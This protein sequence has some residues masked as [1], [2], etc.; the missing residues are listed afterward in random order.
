[1][2]FF[3]FVSVTII[4]LSVWLVAST[5]VYLALLCVMNNC[6]PKQTPVGVETNPGPSTRRELAFMLFQACA[7]LILSGFIYQKNS[8]LAVVIWFCGIFFYARFLIAYR[9]TFFPQSRIV[10]QPRLVGV[11]TNPGP[12]VNQILADFSSLDIIQAYADIPARTGEL[13]R[14]MRVTKRLSL[15]NLK[16]NEKIQKKNLQSTISIS[17]LNSILETLETQKNMVVHDPKPKS[18]R[19]MLWK[20]LG[21]NRHSNL[22]RKNFHQNAI[23]THLAKMHGF[24]IRSLIV[25]HRE[26]FVHNCFD[27]MESDESY[28]FQ[29]S[30]STQTLCADFVP[31]PLLVGI[32]TNPGPPTNSMPLLDLKDSSRA[33]H[34]RRF[35]R[36]PSQNSDVGYD[37]ID[38]QK[39]IRAMRDIKHSQMNL[40]GTT[41]THEISPD[42]EDKITEIVDS[43]NML[44]SKLDMKDQ[45]A[46]MGVVFDPLQNA[47]MMNFFKLLPIYACV[48]AFVCSDKGPVVLK[49][50]VCT[51]ALVVLST[52]TPA[53][54]WSL[55]KDS[56]TNL[57]SRMSR[58]TDGRIEAQ[59]SNDSIKDI[60]SV[61]YTLTTF[62]TVKSAPPGKGLDKFLSSLGDLPKRQDGIEHALLWVVTIIERI[63]NYIR[64]EVLN[65]CPVHI[66]EQ[67]NTD[68]KDWIAKI[69]ILSQEM[70]TNSLVINTANADRVFELIS[71]GNSLLSR[72]GLQKEASGLRSVIGTYMNA[73]KKLQ[74][75]F[76]QANIRGNDLRMSPVCVLLRGASG[77]GKSTITVPLILEI[78]GKLLPVAQLEDFQLNHMDFIYNRQPEHIYWDG[79]RGQMCTI[80][81]DFGQARDVVGTPDNEFMNLIR[82]GNAFPNT[83]HMADL[84]SK[85]VNN[86]RSK[87]VFASTNMRNFNPASII[88]PEAVMRRFDIIVDVI[89]KL[90][91]SLPGYTEDPWSRRLD[92]TKLTSA[93]EPEVYEYMLFSFRE[94]RYV[95]ITTYSA[96]IDT[97]AKMYQQRTAEFEEY[98][99]RIA[100]MKMEISNDRLFSQADCDRN[101]IVYANSLLTLSDLPIPMQSFD[102]DST[103]REAM[104]REC[105]NIITHGVT[106][107]SVSELQLMFPSLFSKDQSFK[108]F[109]NILR[110]LADLP[111]FEERMT[112][113]RMCDASVS[114]FFCKVV[115]STRSRFESYFVEFTTYVAKFLSDHPI[116]RNL[117]MIFIF[118]SCLTISLKLITS[119][120][121]TSEK[122]VVPTAE[123]DSPGH[124]RK[125]KQNRAKLLRRFGAPSAPNAAQLSSEGGADRVCDQLIDKIVSRNVYEVHTPSSRGRIG[126]ATFVRGRLFLIPKH[127]VLSMKISNELGYYFE[128]IITLKSVNSNIEH[129]IPLSVFLQGKTCTSSD[130]QDIV[131][132]EAP[133]NVNP[134]YDIVDN[135]IPTSYASTARDYFTKLVVPREGGLVEYCSHALPVEGIEVHS[136]DGPFLIRKGYQCDAPTSAGDCG[137]FLFVLDPTSKSAKIIGSH[138]AG[139]N[140]RKAFS[141]AIFREDLLYAINLF[142]E[143]VI[144][145]MEEDRYDQLESAPIPGAFVPLFTHELN[146]RQPVRNKVTP[147]RLCDLWGDTKYAPSAL[148]SKTLTDGTVLI[149]MQ[150]ALKTYAGQSMFLDQEVIDQCTDH[151]LSYFINNSDYSKV[152]APC[153]FTFDDAVCGVEGVDFCESLS[154][155][156]SAGF[157]WCVT[158]GRNHPGKTYFFGRDGPFDMTGPGAIEIRQQ[159]E[160]ILVDAR[161]GRRQLHVYTDNLKDEK[162]KIEKVDAC[163]TRLFSGCPLGL[164]IATRMY[165]LDFSMAV[166]RNKISNGIAVGINPYSNDWQVL[167]NQLQSKGKRVIAGDFSGYDGSLQPQVLNSILDFINNW[168]DDGAENKRIRTVLWCEV[169]ASRHING[170][171]IYEW[172]HSLP[173]GH[174]LTVIINSIY[175]HIAF[176]YAWVVAH[177]Y[178]TTSLYT[179]NDNVYCVA[180]GD[181][182]VLNVSDSALEFFNQETMPWLLA[183]IGLK[184][185]N[186]TKD[187]SV[188]ISRELSEVSFLKRK[189]RFDE[190]HDRC[191]APLALESILEMPY[192]TKEGPLSNLITEGNV[193]RCVEELALHSEAVFNEWFPKIYRAS[194]QVLGHVPQMSNYRLLQMKCLSSTVEY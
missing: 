191:L 7:I 77:V 39:I 27:I 174:V 185:T 124:G 127:F 110:R 47:T 73:L 19:M 67:T 152:H 76:D 153:I 108:V 112:Q 118:L 170:N 42:F 1:M 24:G 136:V 121:G 50:T 23:S 41:L 142:S 156:T 194:K 171:D 178:D 9:E 173:S 16:I 12:N 57:F 15:P 146:V 4:C 181:D 123:D 35:P 180:Y 144:C 138:S 140:E 179:Y 115:S 164:Q 8:F 78:L 145:Q 157:P 60:V 40:F 192:W 14:T 175:D 155:T 188:S 62:I 38:K 103:Q 117:G 59:V 56:A 187:D 75:P 183:G 107:A 193:D 122:N 6:F 34:L 22:Y 102:L 26:Y 2:M 49:G 177:Q 98:R 30:V 53:D 168:Y 52:V 161:Q 91:F 64:T 109:M 137:S 150:I 189:W 120:N 87:M 3:S 169:F 61:L 94:N 32:E 21:A 95:S 48:I 54:L 134:H 13:K 97:I 165:F 90:A 133:K 45:M 143:Q 63:V 96:M 72:Y 126:F 129:K 116:I 113:G 111:D 29:K 86:F 33:N 82:C 104:Q 20:Y 17:L 190:A 51:V 71:L 65:Q 186:E 58:Q 132:C 130:G 79:Y 28:S 43:V 88:E 68:V 31:Q 147:S 176:R 10:P 131:M 162:R 69:E 141:S 37:K 36:Q 18:L 154:R 125:G 70:H 148:R 100:H 101:S 55:I 46:G 167:A 84:S 25:G 114:S 139:D 83:L 105:I 66:L 135:F 80:F 99:D 92:K 89:P 151:Y 119:L 81:D 166:M 158:V 74:L 163:K 85:G 5:V 11:E 182:N 44:S 159:V 172:T 106:N 128:E 160:S 149:P 93:L 184:Y